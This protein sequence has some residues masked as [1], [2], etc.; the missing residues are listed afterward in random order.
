MKQT[1]KKYSETIIFGKYKGKSFRYILK[2]NPSYILWLD[3]ENIVKM[4]SSLVNKA[5][6]ANNSLSYD[7]FSYSSHADD[8]PTYGGCDPNMWGDIG[9]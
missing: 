6:E 8:D 1:I 7:N 3:R 5:R 2:E 9:I 4:P